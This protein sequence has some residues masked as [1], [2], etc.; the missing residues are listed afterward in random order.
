MGKANGLHQKVIVQHGA[1]PAA[2]TLGL[3]PLVIRI[4]LAVKFKIFVY[5]RVLLG[6]N[7]L[8][9]DLGGGRIDLG[10][11]IRCCH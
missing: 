6:H 7:P 10:T 9:K 5:R 8:A 2:R 3:G 11:A 1:L 4:K